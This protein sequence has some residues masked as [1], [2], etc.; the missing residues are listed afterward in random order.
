MNLAIKKDCF[1]VLLIYN[2][3]LV[4]VVY[5]S[6]SMIHIHVSTL[7]QILFPYR[8][9]AECWVEFPTLYSRFL[10][11]VIYSIYSTVHTSI[12]VSQ[13]IPQPLYTLV[14]TKF[15]S[16]ICGYFVNSFN[17]FLDTTCKQYHNCLCLACFTHYESLWVHRCPCKWR[18]A[19]LF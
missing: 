12:P 5:Q 4:S 19:I 14:I 16:Y 13:F 2:A 7:L 17:I 18:Y 9:F 11:I 1:G 6:E 15:V 8:S 10:L 3:V